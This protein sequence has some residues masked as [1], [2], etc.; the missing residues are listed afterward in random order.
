M[1]IICVSGNYGGTANEPT[2]Y[3]KADSSL[4]KSNKPYYL[5]YFTKEMTAGIEMVYRISRLG[6]NIKEKFADRYYDSVALGIGLTARDIQER[7]RASGS[8]WEI[9]EA[10]DGSAVISEFIKK[11]DLSDNKNIK[12]SL[13][14]NGETRQT[15]ETVM[16]TN[17]ADRI[18][19]YVSQYCTLKIGDLIYTGTPSEKIRIE[20]GE[21]LTGKIDGRTM[22]DME[23]R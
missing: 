10:F 18:I 12:F 19:A 9:S 11:E 5:P 17:T 3:M 23:I 8:P 14:I 6:K 1:K 22:I 13:E 20:P 2:I 21:R 16:M 15:G 7:L 4:L